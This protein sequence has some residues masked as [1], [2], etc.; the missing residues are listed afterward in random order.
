MEDL[1]KWEF[2]FKFGENGRKNIVAVKQCKSPS[3]TKVYKR[4]EES[5][6]DGFIYS[7]GYNQIK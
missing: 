1:K 7:Y 4:L 5:F 3:R 2:Y 6:N